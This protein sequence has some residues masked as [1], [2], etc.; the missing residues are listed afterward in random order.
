MSDDM[1]IFDILGGAPEVKDENVVPMKPKPAAQSADGKPFITDKAKEHLDKYNETQ[2]KDEDKI[3]VEKLAPTGRKGEITYTDVNREIQRRRKEVA[4]AKA[5]EMKEKYKSGPQKEKEPDE[6]PADRLALYAG[7]EHPIPD[8]TWKLEQVRAHLQET[9]KELSAE[10]CDMLYDKE[11][12][13]VIPVL[14]GHRKGNGMP[15]GSKPF[16]VYDSI[17]PGHGSMPVYRIMGH[18][19]VYEVRTTQTGTFVAKVP[20]KLTPFEGFH[21][22]I[23]R[24]GSSVLREVVEEFRM[25]PDKEMLANI[26]FDRKQ[27]YPFYAEFPDQ[28]GTEVSVVADGSIET[29]DRFIALQIHSHAAMPAFFSAQDD[30]DELRT[31]LY[32]VIGRCNRDKPEMKLRYSCGGIFVDC[33]PQEVFSYGWE[34]FVTERE[35]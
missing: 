17:P 31:G 25:N 32:G 13:Y 29:P 20:A 21:L 34:L 7:N 30:R 27:L 23:P 11:N 10:R 28:E 9:Y 4:E 18:D 19:G 6:Y 15:E 26:I 14:K 22:K 12:H 2:K 3:L 8:T 35:S 1:N 16:S 24:I 5:A 33:K